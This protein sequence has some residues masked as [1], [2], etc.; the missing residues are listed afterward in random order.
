MYA[1]G[2]WAASL[3]YFGSRRD[4]GSR[5]NQGK[6][7]QISVVQASAKYTLG[8]GVD[9]QGLVGYGDFR[10]STG[11]NTIAQSAENGTANRGW[12]VMTGVA[13]QF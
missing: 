4:G 1:T 13:V 2:P 8:P 10:N 5:T 9:L 3:S 12:A 7:E 6:K 11:N